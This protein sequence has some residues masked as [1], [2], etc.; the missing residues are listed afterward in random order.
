[1]EDILLLLGMLIIFSAVLFIAWLTTR[2]LGRKMAGASK[3]R[4]MSVVETLQVGMDRYLYLIKAG[5]RFFLFYTTRKGMELVSEINID[6]EA[7]AAKDEASGSGSGFN[8]K[9]IFDFYSGLSRK[10]K[11]QVTEDIEPDRQEEADEQRQAGLPESIKKLRK[12]N[13]NQEEDQYKG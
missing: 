8:F 1:M 6:E 13:H 11:S 3:N 4:L 12:L 7:L 9:R 5:D 10:G 2:L